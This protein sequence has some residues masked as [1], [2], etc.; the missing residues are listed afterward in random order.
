MPLNVQEETPGPP[1]FR[2]AGMPCQPSIFRG[3]LLNV[4][5]SIVSAIC[6]QI[7][8]HELADALKEH[9]AHCINQTLC[10]LSPDLRSPASFG[11]G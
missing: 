3:D 4:N 2:T 11:H 1:L 6:V 9:V 7:T 5:A 8:N 10:A